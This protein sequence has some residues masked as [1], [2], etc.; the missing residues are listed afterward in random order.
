MN[1]AA[2]ENVKDHLIV[3]SHQYG[4]AAEKAR[5]EGMSKECIEMYQD[6]AKLYRQLSEDRRLHLDN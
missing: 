3:Q 1:K 6:M 4:K 5:Q 2:I